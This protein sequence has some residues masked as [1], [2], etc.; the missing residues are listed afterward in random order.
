MLP[1]VLVIGKDVVVIVATDVD[2]ILA[3]AVEVVIVTVVVGTSIPTTNRPIY[4]FIYSL[5][6][7]QPHKSEIKLYIN[8]RNE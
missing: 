6:V 3:V 8:S 4:I 5:C 1:N 2:R 7:F